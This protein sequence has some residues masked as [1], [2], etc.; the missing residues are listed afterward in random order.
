MSGP[1][2]SN[3]HTETFLLLTLCI[4]LCTFHRPIKIVGGAAV[5]A[6][7]LDGLEVGA[8]LL[9]ELIDVELDPEVN[10]TGVPDLLA[11]DIV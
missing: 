5:V 4:A 8:W 11:V 3:D 7:E 9:D 10:G 2:L 1:F 6:A